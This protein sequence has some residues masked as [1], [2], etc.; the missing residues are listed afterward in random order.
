MPSRRPIALLAASSALLLAAPAAHAVTLSSGHLDFGARLAGGKLRAQIKDDTGGRV[1]W[2]N[3]SGVTIKVGGRAKTRLPQSSALG[4]LGRP[5]KR[6]WLIPQ[7]QRGGV[8]WLGWNTQ[9]LGPRKVR[10]P[11]TWSLTGFSG[12]GRMGVYQVGTFGSV[13]VLFRSTSRGSRSVPLGVHAHGNWAFTRPGAYRA[14]F[15]WS[16]RSTGGRA[17]S[18][19]GTLRFRVG[20]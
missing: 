12:P 3:P 8:P 2:R 10:G 16:A 13:D 15:R 19:S 20:R 14:T 7:T 1:V 6:V 11:V 5:G 4:F 18:D 9:Q 17:L